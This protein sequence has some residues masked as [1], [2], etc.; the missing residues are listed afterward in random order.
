DLPAGKNLAGAFWQP[1]AVICDP[2]VL[3]TLPGEYFDDGTAEALKYGVIA[4]EELFGMIASGCTGE[5]LS[6]IIARCVAIKAE[7]VGRD[8]FDRGER[9]LLNLGHTIGHAVEKCSSF[10]ISHGRGV[11]IGMAMIARSAEAQGWCATG[12]A[13]KITRALEAC[14]LPVTSPFAV[15]ELLKYMIND[16]KR[17]GADITLVIPET[18]GRCALRTVPAN[19]L[20]Q[21]LTPSKG[22]AHV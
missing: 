4:D 6:D 8:E 9:A 11:A 21:L 22:A 7:I 2:D 16:K 5:T 12:T 19:A 18:I 15:D 1:S 17:S 14:R 3:Q 13:D 10:T 20:A